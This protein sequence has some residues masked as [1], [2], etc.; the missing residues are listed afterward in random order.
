MVMNAKKT[1]ILTHAHDDQFD[2]H[3]PTW[4]DR[5]K[6]SFTARGR[7]RIASVAIPLEDSVPDIVFTRQPAGAP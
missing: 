7:G 4:D 1:F 3:E 5:L 2:A 6:L